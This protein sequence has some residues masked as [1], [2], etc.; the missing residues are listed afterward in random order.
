MFSTAE[1]LIPRAQKCVARSGFPAPILSVSSSW[2]RIFGLGFLQT[3]PHNDALALLLTLGSANTWY[4]DL[5]P[6]SHVPCLAHTSQISRPKKQSEAALFW[7]R[8]NLPCYAWMFLCG[9]ISQ[10]LPFLNK[11][12]GYIIVHVTCM[13]CSAR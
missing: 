4:R 11:H 8:L 5:H 12:Y 3:P 1:L 13:T 10:Y 6:V 7:G 2:H 9:L